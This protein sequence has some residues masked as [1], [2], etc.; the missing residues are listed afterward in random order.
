MANQAIVA[1]VGGGLLNRARGQSTVAAVIANNFRMQ[2]DHL[3]FR[4]DMSLGL[5]D[6][7]LRAARSTDKKGPLHVFGDVLV[8]FRL[9]YVDATDALNLCP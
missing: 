6:E 2:D 7:Y 5:M 1:G 4:D 8:A 3:H 9:R